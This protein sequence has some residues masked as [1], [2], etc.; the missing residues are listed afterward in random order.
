VALLVG[1][2]GKTRE[3]ALSS[4][5]VFAAFVALYSVLLHKELRFLFPG[6]PFAVTATALALN[7]LW[8]VGPK[9]K[10]E[11]DMRKG[12][13]SEASRAGEGSTRE[14]EGSAEVRRGHRAAERTPGERTDGARDQGMERSLRARLMRGFVRGGVASA[15]LLSLAAT[16]AFLW[17]S[18][19]NYP[20]AEAMM[21]LAN[22]ARRMRATTGGVRVHVDVATAMSGVTRFG[23]QLWQRLPEGAAWSFSKAEDLVNPCTGEAMEQGGRAEDYLHGG[24]SSSNAH[25]ASAFDS[26]APS[27]SSSGKGI[28]DSFG[29]FGFLLTANPAPFTQSPPPGSADSCGAFR[30]VGVVHGNPRLGVQWRNFQPAL[31]R[32]FAAA[33]QQRFPAQDPSATWPIPVVATEPVIYILQRRK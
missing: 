32:A 23:E 16:G 26:S 29:P 33:L 10:E 6:M 28:P 11:F 14:K 22:I 8:S 20:G 18:S 4:F 12:V 27:S 1:G 13:S 19:H 30:V 31:P 24:E 21:H 17:V 3:A 25:A 5:V 9:E 2:R 7:D 15:L